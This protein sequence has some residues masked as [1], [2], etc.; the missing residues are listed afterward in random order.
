MLPKLT[1]L[2]WTPKIS[3]EESVA[4]MIHEDLKEAQR[5]QLDTM[6]KNHQTQKWDP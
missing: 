1:K 2:D 5:E 4:E 3:F 6:T